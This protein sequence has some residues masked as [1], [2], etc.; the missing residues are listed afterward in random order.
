MAN[1][2]T[3][4]AAPRAAGAIPLRKDVCPEAAVARPKISFADC[5]ALTKR[6]RLVSGGKSG[7][8][9]R[10]RADLPATGLDAGRS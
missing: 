8:A 3:M 7:R 5:E 2:L 1:L 10:G 9:V 6:F 4:G